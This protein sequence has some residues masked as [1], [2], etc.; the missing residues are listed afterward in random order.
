GRLDEAERR[1]LEVVSLG[2]PLGP[3]EL[4]AVADLGLVEDLVDKGLLVSRM[5]GRRV[6]VRVAHPLYGEVL[7]AETPALRIPA[8]TRALAGAVE[9]TGARRRED[10]LRDATWSLRSGAARPGLM[11]EAAGIAR[12]RYDFPLAERL[13]RAAMADGAGFEASLLA[14]QLAALQGRAEDALEE[15]ARLAA[16]AGTDAQR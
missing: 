2:E 6:E 11:L 14:A 7:R 15:F 3:A 5:D 12:W 13:A 1:L 8:I 16:E 9:A 4:G 10:M